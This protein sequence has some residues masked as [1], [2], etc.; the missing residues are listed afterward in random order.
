MIST[1]SSL[2]IIFGMYYYL[3]IIHTDRHNGIMMFS[4]FDCVPCNTRVQK[5]HWNHSVNKYVCNTQVQKYHWNQS[6]IKYVMFQLNS[7][8]W[9]LYNSFGTSN[10]LF[11]TSRMLT[12]Y[13]TGR[14]HI[15]Q[16]KYASSRRLRFLQHST[17]HTG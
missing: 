4:N 5:Y 10:L 1:S 12:F 11:G 9:S 7:K 15:T 8:L 16:Y 13:S 14:V 2:C 17:V 3:I 6:V